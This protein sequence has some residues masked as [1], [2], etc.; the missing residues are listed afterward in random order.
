MRGLRTAGALAALLL[1]LAVAGPAQE[2]S[3]SLA[4]GRFFA[5]KP[6]YR[7]IYGQG[8][9]LAGDVWLKLRGPIG[10]AAGFG[11][12]ADSGLAVPLSGGDEAYPLDI[13]R[14]TVPLLVFYEAALA[15]ID[16]RIGAGVGIHSYKEVWPTEGI[17]FEGDKVSARW[18]LTASIPL[19][20]RLSLLVLASYESISTG[21]GSPLDAN[22]NLG[23]FQL[24]GGLSFRLFR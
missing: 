15:G 23:G 22:V 2:I 10:F 19:L 21:A 5:S 17:S 8:T 1:A 18:A 3:V 7:E 11:R 24:L 6:A 4:A 16:V 13:R 20:D 9:V 14:T 12:V